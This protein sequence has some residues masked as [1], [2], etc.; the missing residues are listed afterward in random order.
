MQV[1]RQAPALIAAVQNYTTMLLLQA[2]PKVGLL[3]FLN[4]NTSQLE[5]MAQPCTMQPLSCTY[6]S[7]GWGY[8]HAEHQ[9]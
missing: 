5:S 4:D 3:K 8:A 1:G 2:T 6:L 7:G 9:R